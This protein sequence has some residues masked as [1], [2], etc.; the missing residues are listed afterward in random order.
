MLRLSSGRR[1]SRG[2]T[3][4]SAGSRPRCGRAQINRRNLLTLCDTGQARLLTLS[5]TVLKLLI[6][7]RHQGRVLKIRDTGDLSQ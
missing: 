3:A 1:E 7:A 2:R 5:D 4:S 6:G